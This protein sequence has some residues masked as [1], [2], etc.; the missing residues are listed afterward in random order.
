MREALLSEKLPDSRVRCNICQW[1]CNIAPGKSGV[2][3]MYHNRDGVLYNMSLSLI[4]I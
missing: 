4:H 3:R 2:C 1:R